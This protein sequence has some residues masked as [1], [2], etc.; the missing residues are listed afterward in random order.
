MHRDT[1][2]IPPAER[3][4]RKLYVGIRGLFSHIKRHTLRQR[5]RRAVNN[6]IRGAAHIRFPAIGARPAPAAVTL[7]F[8]T[9]RANSVTSSG[10]FISGLQKCPQPYCF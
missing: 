10:K 8:S 9:T 7:L 5:Q 4:R 2:R 6:R 1:P 3:L